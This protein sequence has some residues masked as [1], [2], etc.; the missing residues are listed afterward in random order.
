MSALSITYIPLIKGGHLKE[1]V[2]LRHVVQADG[3]T[4]WKVA[5]ADQLVS[6]LIIGKANTDRRMM[7]KTSVV[8]LLIDL[9][10]KR[11]R[12]LVQTSTGDAAED[13]GLDDE[14]DQ[15]DDKII[16]WRK[17]P[18]VI[19]ITAP[20]IGE[21]TGIPLQVLPK[22][23]RCLWLELSPE[24]L[25]YLHSAAIHEIT[26]G[27]RLCSRKRHK[28]NHEAEVGVTWESRR[29]AFRGR[30][31]SGRSKYFNTKDHDDDEDARAA[32]IAWSKES[33]EEGEGHNE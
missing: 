21:A 15:P 5:K 29:S 16:D 1:P 8:E 19:T 31:R 4:F 6:R 9:S 11:V 22:P 12:E 30:R 18:N 13:L 25:D 33:D 32:A 20:T 28:D 3:M 17:V 10:H 14:E 26:N 24:S 23:G 2:Q 7:S 27:Q